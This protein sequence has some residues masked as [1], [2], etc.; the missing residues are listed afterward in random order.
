MKYL[1]RAVLIALLGAPLCAQAKIMS[2]VFEGEMASF[3]NVVIVRDTNLAF[4]ATISGVITYDT[5]E[6]GVAPTILGAVYKLISVELIFKSQTDVVLTLTTNDAS[7]N[8]VLAGSNLYVPN[9][10][11]TNSIGINWGGSG[12]GTNISPY[13]PDS[14]KIILPIKSG[15]SLPNEATNNIPVIPF[16]GGIEVV[17][18][19]VKITGKMT[20]AELVEG[21]KSKATS[22]A[23]NDSSSGGALSPITG[24]LLLLASLVFSRRFF[25]RGV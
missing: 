8:M 19:G 22:S 16:D 20:D 13:S 12:L 3:S 24:S 25:R 21:N 11:V 14:F 2:I 15:I 9:I 23:S 1:L 17:L 7:M 10:N 6:T 18:S 5:N 4:P